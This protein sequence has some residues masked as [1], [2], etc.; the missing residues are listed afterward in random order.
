MPI[1]GTAA[2]TKELTDLFVEGK[3]GD[4]PPDFLLRI[5]DAMAEVAAPTFGR[6]LAK[7]AEPDGTPA[8]FHCT[9]GKDR[10]GL[11]AALLLSVLGVDEATILDDYELSAALYSADQLARLQPRARGCRHRSRALPRR[12]RRT[13][14]RHGCAAGDPARAVRVGRGLPHGGGRR[15]HRDVPELRARLVEAPGAT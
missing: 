9:Q 13:E 7:L 1:G 12:V 5:Y 3:F 11:T 8:L 10:T 4:I 6:L 2:K 15:R 14:A